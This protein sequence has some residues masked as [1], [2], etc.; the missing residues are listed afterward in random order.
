VLANQLDEANQEAKLSRERGAT[1]L[2]VLSHLQ[3]EETAAAE[4]LRQ[5]QAELE[6]CMHVYR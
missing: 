5:A 3:S 2:V 1:A 6:V 4:R